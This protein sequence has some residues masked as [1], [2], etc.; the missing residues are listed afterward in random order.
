M[1]MMREM[2]F[3]LGLQVNQSPCGIFINQSKYVLEILKKYGME[4]YDLVGNPMEIKDKLDLDQNGT[5]VDATKYRSMIGALMYLMSSRPD[6][7]HATCLSARY[8]AKL[9]EKH[10]KEV[11]RIFHYLRGTVNTGV[12]YTKVFGFELTGFLDANYAGCKDTF[13]STSGGAQFLGE[14][15]VSWS[16]K[17]QDCTA[18]STAKSEYVSTAKAEYMPK[19][20]S[21]GAQFLGE[22]LS[23]HQT[24]L[25]RSGNE[26]KQVWRTQCNHV[27]GSNTLSWKPCQEGS[28][29]INLPVHRI[30][31][32]RDNLILAESKFKTSCSI[33]KDK[34]MMKAQYM[35][36]ERLLASFQDLEH[37]GGDTRTASCGSPSSNNN[38][39]P[40]VVRPNG[41]AP[42]LRSMKELCHSSINRHGRPI[43][44]IPI[45]ATD[46]GLCHPMIQHVQNSCQFHGLLGDDVNR[47]IDKF[48]EVNQHI[49]QNK[50][51]DDAHRLSLFPD[52]LTD[53]ATAWYDRLPRNSI[54]SFDDMMRKFLSK[55]FPPSMVTKL[56]NEI[57]NFR[58]DPNESL[59][60]A[61]ECY[62]LSIDCNE[63]T[64]TT[65]QTQMSNM[66]MELR[67]EFKSSI[68]TK[69]NKI[70]NQN[71]QI[72]NMLTNLTM[73]RQSPSGSGSL[74]SNTIANPRG[75]V[76]TIAIL[77]GAENRPP[78]LEKDMY[79]SWRSR[80][81]LYMLN[82]QHGRMILEF[83]EHGPLLWP[84]VTEDGVTRLK[85]YSELSS[86]EATQADCDVKEINIIL[87]ALPLEIYA[88]V[89][90]H[91][92]FESSDL[93]K[94]CEG[95]G[96][97]VDVYI[98]NRKSKADKR[99]AF[100]RFI[101][102]ENIGRLVGNL[103]TIWIGRLHIH[104]N[105]VRY[106]RLRKPSNL[107]GYVHTN[108]VKVFL[109][110][111]VSEYISDDESLHGAKNRSVGS[112]HGDHVLEDDSDVEGVSKTIFG[113][114]P[115]SLNN[116]ACNCDA[117]GLNSTFSHPPGFTS[118]VREIR[119]ENE[120]V[121][122]DLYNETDKE[123]SPMVHAKVMNFSQEGGS[124]L[125][126]MDGMIRVGQSMGYA[127]EGCMKDIEHTIGTQGIDVW[128]GFDVMVEQAWNSLSHTDSNGLTRF[129]KKLQDL[130]KIIRS[131]VKDKKSQQSG[132]TKSIKDELT[133][134]DKC[135][136]SGNV[137][138]EMLFKRMELMRQLWVL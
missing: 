42:D 79:Y 63:A 134:I 110:H 1:S 74:P 10:L 120:H 57:T 3:F 18:L 86:A 47:H 43:A 121:G 40:P 72:M 11:K 38:G 15:L 88:L 28:S 80:M 135:L 51:S 95:Y 75:D 20:T 67:N 65:M 2:T 46:F 92:N 98:P 85:N 132:A 123:T 78:M 62:K 73:Q 22:K 91:K 82:R 12:W 109:E 66:K 7:V 81:E 99:F 61:W 33:I 5:L 89:S 59:F 130:N 94:L 103:C 54:Q 37:E 68:E 69:T 55:Y 119:Q 116:S 49:N 131:W 96:K 58:Q 52:S 70:E 83:V 114:K 115:S 87:Q 17:K 137:F 84:S 23:Q 53:H 76:T 14:K 13:K 129:K 101:R 133:N 39:P 108:V 35:L 138:E 127:M 25:R 31:R 64:L 24:A 44:S 97:V 60:E 118:E 8:Q 128:D 124:I 26:N 136:D 30:R 77:S 106:E 113:D 112:Q 34:Y 107:A 29:K 6:I 104:A 100:I 32:W 93:W 71:I 111:K 4:S 90:T 50:V 48:L 125:E 122:V 102:V 16:S 19:S 105:V 56:R 27:R 36:R 126:V 9:T 21:G 41:P 45:Q 117:Q